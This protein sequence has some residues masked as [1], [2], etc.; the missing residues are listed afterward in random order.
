MTF[1]DLNE[2]TPKGAPAVM[3]LIW[4]SWW[5]QWKADGD[6]SDVTEGSPSNKTMTHRSQPRRLS[7]TWVEPPEHWPEPSQPSLESRNLQLN[8]MRY[9]GLK[10]WRFRGSWSL[11]HRMD[12]LK[13]FYSW[14]EAGKTELMPSYGGLQPWNGGRSTP[15]IVLCTPIQ[16]WEQAW[17][18]LIGSLNQEMCLPSMSLMAPTLLEWIKNLYC[19]LN[20]NVSMSYSNSL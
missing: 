14:Y 3:P 4:K 10:T 6:L 1:T 5:R 13:C 15:R 12:L 7:G 17:L 18:M 16:S 20:D 2:H 8:K 9:K 11:A 19:L